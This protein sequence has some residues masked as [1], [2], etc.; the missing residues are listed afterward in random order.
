[1]ITLILLT[2]CKWYAECFDVKLF[3]EYN[4]GGFRWSKLVFIETGWLRPLFH[5]LIFVI[6][7]QVGEGDMS[8]FLSLFQSIISLHF[9][10]VSTLYPLEVGQAQSTI[11]SIWRRL[12]SFHLLRISQICSLKRLN[13]KNLKYELSCCNNGGVDSY[14]LQSVAILIN[15]TQY[16]TL[17]KFS[18]FLKS[19]QIFA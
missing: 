3:K 19:V 2:F 12:D 11:V 17:S 18:C 6:S 13:F 4:L 9:R 7:K 15:H 14:L 5:L 1:M 10:F 8:W 16:R